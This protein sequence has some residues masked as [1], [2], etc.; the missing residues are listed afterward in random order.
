MPFKLSLELPIEKYL[1]E[2]LVLLTGLSFAFFATE[3]ITM[4]Q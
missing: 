1:L 2:N 3:A 4:H